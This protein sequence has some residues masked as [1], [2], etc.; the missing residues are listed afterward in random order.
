MQGNGIEIAYVL[1]YLIGMIGVGVVV[2]RRAKGSDEFIAGGR[3]MPYW[4]VT[5]TLFATWWGGGTM[6]GSAG[7]AFYDGF[8]GI[9]YEPIGAGLTL[10]LGVYWKKAN[11]SGAIAGMIVGFVTIFVWMIGAGSL[12]PEP[13]WLSTLG[14]GT[15]GGL[16]MVVVS[17]ATQKKSPAKPLIATDGTIL[18]FGDLAK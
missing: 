9:I 3:R 2:S 17:L 7:A 4:L 15:L 11:T 1:I 5:G 18:K 16:T 6:M 14:P 10:V 12:F 8:H 13:E